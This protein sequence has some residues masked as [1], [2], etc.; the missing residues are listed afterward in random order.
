MKFL[1]LLLPLLFLGCST[2]EPS[3][4][5]AK[6]KDPSPLIKI[7]NPLAALESPDN[8]ALFVVQEGGKIF[9]VENDQITTWLDISSRTNSTGDIGMAFS[10]QWERDRLFYVFFRN[11]GGAITL[12]EGAEEDDRGSVRRTVFRFYDADA[13]P[14][15]IL[16]QGSNLLLAIRG[17]ESRRGWPGSLLRI[18]PFLST[19]KAYSLP[20]DNIDG[21]VWRRGLGDITSLSL[22]EDKLWIV[23][24]NKLLEASPK[25]PKKSSL[26]EE[27]EC[28]RGGASWL[29]TFYYGSSCTGEI[30]SWPSGDRI[31]E[32]KDLRGLAATSR[33][34]LVLAKRGIY[35]M[36]EER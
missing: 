3:A 2:E 20:R 30:F 28:L 15:P 8:D 35:Q 34:P 4:P 31:G 36:P 26:Q 24:G 6:Q 14:G 18:R 5:L 33:Q 27:L 11:R 32:V 29:N 22:A 10:P 16:F 23:S 19:G 25:D 21:E 7:D 17:A 12:L 9:R 13:L 1:I